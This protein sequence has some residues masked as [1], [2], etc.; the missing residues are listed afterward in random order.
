MADSTALFLMIGGIVAAGIGVPVGTGILA[1]NLTASAWKKYT[2]FLEERNRLKNLL[3]EIES[4][5][6]RWP[7]HVRPVLFK[8]IDRNAQFHFSNVEHALLRSEEL[9]IN[10]L[11]PPQLPSIPIQQFSIVKNSKRIIECWDLNDKVNELT[12]LLNNAQEEI[13]ILRNEHIKEND[14]EAKLKIAYGALFARAQEE[15]SKIVPAKITDTNQIR[16]D[17]VSE[18]IQNCIRDAEENLT[19]PAEDKSNFAAANIL[20]RLANYILDDFQIYNKSFLI[21]TRFEPDQF[22]AK[23]ARLEETLQAIVNGSSLK[24]WRALYEADRLL[25]VADANLSDTIKSMEIFNKMQ[26]LFLSREELFLANHLESMIKSSE[27][28]QKECI[29]YWMTPQEGQ[30]Y[31][32]LALKGLD[33]PSTLLENIHRYNQSQ[34]SPLTTQGVIIKQSKLPTII[35]YLNKMILDVRSAQKDIQSL[36][37]LLEIH[38]N[39]HKKVL[40]R[41]DENGITRIKVQELEAIEKDTSKEV[42][43]KCITQR[44]SFDKFVQRAKVKRGAN[45]PELLELLDTLEGKCLQIKLEHKDLINK[46]KAQCASLT[47]DLKNKYADLDRY[48]DERPLLE[49]DWES[50]MNKVLKITK[51]YNSANTS[52]LELAT[53]YSTAYQTIE[54]TKKDIEAITSSRANYVKQT[55]A[56]KQRL[57]ILAS[58]LSEYNK[59]SQGAW[60]WAK[61]KISQE[62][63]PINQ[64]YLNLR[65][66]LVTAGN[67]ETIQLSIRQIEEIIKEAEK[68]Q[69]SIDTTLANIR[70]E[71]EA[72][73]DNFTYLEKSALNSFMKNEKNRVLINKIYEYAQIVP[74]HRDVVALYESATELLRQGVTNEKVDDIEKSINDLSQKIDRI[75]TVQNVTQ[76]IGTVNVRD[77]ATANIA[78]TIN[79]FRPPITPGS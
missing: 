12:G 7:I 4:E 39:A 19:N 46:L 63:Q 40:E 2:F 48:R 23:L 14:I 33:L 68:A 11:P 5:S 52:Y 24:S 71:N 1:D 73:I 79:Q 30:E 27:Q 53:Y 67:M 18:T 29:E 42:M 56:A 57:A 65:Q 59:F 21:P 15:V 17:W 69:N 61:K 74:D 54:G 49:W 41:I 16:K 47:K 55:E 51:Q 64:K 9:E 28:L 22:N 32:S 43:N 66:R 34:V 45:Y 8:G 58:A 44:Q 38:K 75:K 62:L 26:K 70:R 10:I 31:W 3:N 6:W 37:D 76:N 13:A 50:T 35:S 20:I 78:G 77:G 72:D 60:Q 25:E 36:K